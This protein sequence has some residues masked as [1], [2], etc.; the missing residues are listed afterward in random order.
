MLALPRPHPSGADAAGGRR[1]ARLAPSGAGV[2]A[3][4]PWLPGMAMYGLVVGVA[5]GRAGL[6]AG[7]GFAAA[8]L[9][10]SGGAQV[11]AAG[12]LGA[13]A[14]PIV[15]VAT[16]LA[17][18][19]R[20]VIYSAAAG[21]YWR[22]TPRWWRALAAYLLVDPSFA[23]GYDR[24]R[25]DEPDRRAAHA[26]YLGAALVLFAVWMSACATGAL[27]A[28][29]LPES[30]QLGFVVPLFLV[31][32]AERRITSPAARRACLVTAAVAAV[33]RLAPLHLGVLAAVVIGL[34]V[35]L[36]TTRDETAD[37]A[38]APVAPAGT[39]AGNETADP[40]PETQDTPR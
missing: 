20:L 18:N 23:V 19:A 10:Y 15:V 22:G 38:V 21:P 32:E 12:L 33:G 35:A 1:R 34:A 30:L 13:G 39:A 36:A 6:P 14:A 2:R 8:P 16:V 29:H 24:Y 4:A 37:A 40:S 5:A 25:L 11:A 26:H 9:I 17:I 3:M 31:G 28:G 27:A 7:A